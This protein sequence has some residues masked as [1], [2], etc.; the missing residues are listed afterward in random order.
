VSLVEKLEHCLRTGSFGPLRG[1]YAADA[2]FQAFLPSGTLVRDGPDEIVAVFSDW[3]PCEGTLVHWNPSA[4]EDGLALVFERHP[5]DPERPW[6]SRH[7]QEIRVDDGH[8][9]THLSWSDMPR[10]VGHF[11]V[12]PHAIAGLIDGGRRTPL[13]EG[14]FSGSRLERIVMPDGRSYFLK[15]ISPRRDL[16][17]RL[18]GDSG[19]EASLFTSGA[20]NRVA[21]AIEYPV[22]AVAP[23]QDGWAILMRDVSDAL[24]LQREHA[25][26]AD[27][28]TS[29]ERRR[30]L[31]A[32][33]RLHEAFR[34]EPIVAACSVVDR[35]R[36]LGPHVMARE[37]SGPDALPRWIRGSWQAFYDL[38][39]ADVGA[40]VAAIHE[41]PEPF[42]ARLTTAATTLIH[43]DLWA[44]NIGLEADR[45]VLLDWALACRAPMEMEY[46]FWVLW[47]TEGMA[48]SPDALLDDVRAVAGDRIDEPTLHLAFLG[49]L[50]SGAG[51][52]GWAWNSVNHPDPATRERDRDELKWWIDRARQALEHAW[53][54]L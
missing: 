20:L 5:V 18:T 21:D 14:G 47:N 37:A 40:A 34:N 33:R 45:V 10:H 44:P 7:W 48:V 22:L 30:I 23:E 27:S 9:V 35:L 2:R 49:E 42:A 52:R 19:R 51:A 24:V 50:V 43:G 1:D 54:P 4:Y 16:F 31:R 13:Y 39:P 28:P 26:S 29:L 25:S 11:P 15:H 17:L 46:A 38:V 41:D 8:I 12:L 53:S 36:M 3:W 6:T 32:V